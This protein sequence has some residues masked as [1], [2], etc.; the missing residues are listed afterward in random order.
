MLY[1]TLLGFISDCTYNPFHLFWIFK[2]KRE[3]W[4]KGETNFK[5]IVIGKKWC[6]PRESLTYIIFKKG[7]YTPSPL[8]FDRYMYADLLV[9]V[10]GH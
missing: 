2:M 4:I 3:R 5:K 10:Y 9:A 8:Y 1:P 6:F 7:S